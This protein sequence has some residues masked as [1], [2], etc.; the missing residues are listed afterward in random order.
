MSVP[1][2]KSLGSKR[3]QISEEQ[4]KTIT[5]WFGDFTANE[6]VKI[7]NNEDFGYSRITVERPLRLNFAVTAERL[8]KLQAEPAFIKLKEAQQTAIIHL[9]KTLNDEH[10]WENREIFLKVLK[11][12][13]KEQTVD[14][15]GP[16]FKTI[17]QALSERDEQAEVCKDSKGNPEADADL[18]DYENI[19]LRE[20]IE[21]YFQREVISHASDAWIDHSKTKVG[22]EIPFNR[23]FYKYMPPRSLKEI[24]ADLDKVSAEIMLLLQEVH[25]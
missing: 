23:H 24:D 12:A 21:S 4:I 19:P 11:M 9:L 2:R 8:A 15:K 1:M 7:F 20:D 22:Y 13:F 3:K 17:W 10:V 14:I 18:R 16:L 25:V 6:Q 5:R